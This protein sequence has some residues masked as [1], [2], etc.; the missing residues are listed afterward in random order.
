ME[1]A[2]KF[3]KFKV[4]NHESREEFRKN[5]DVVLFVTNMK[6]YAKENN[7]RISYGASHSGDNPWFVSEVPTACV[8]LSYTNHLYDLPM[9]KTYVNA[10]GDTKEYIH[11][12]VEKLTGRSQF[13]GKA[14][15]LVWCGRW[16]TRI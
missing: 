9:M 8:S 3:N 14:N 11:A 13:K 2:S 7:V 1:G 16:E 15:D 4:M 12:L 5:T 6:G 10:Y